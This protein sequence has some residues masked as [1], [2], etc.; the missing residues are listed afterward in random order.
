MFEN[1]PESPLLCQTLFVDDRLTGAERGGGGVLFT[2]TA[3]TTLMGDAGIGGPFAVILVGDRLSSA[4]AKVY[5]SSGWIM[6]CLPS[7]T[8]K[9]Y[10]D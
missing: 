5:N 3:D 6:V 7:K 2:G 8:G 1:V 10:S 4:A 9:K